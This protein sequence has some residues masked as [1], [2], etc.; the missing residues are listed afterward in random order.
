VGGKWCKAVVVRESSGVTQYQFESWAA[1]PTW[2]SLLPPSDTRPL[3]RL[4]PE[5][6]IEVEAHICALWGEK[7]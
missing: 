7:S 5:V 4:Y 2:P 3:A 1:P 6:P